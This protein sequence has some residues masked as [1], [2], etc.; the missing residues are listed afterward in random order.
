M[1]FS[2]SQNQ[3][4]ASQ[5]LSQMVALNI[6]AAAETRI[7]VLRAFARVRSS[8]LKDASSVRTPVFMAPGSFQNFR[9]DFPKDK[10]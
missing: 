7:V 5:T 1:R 4:D 8:T 6:I 9:F 10:Q 2:T 3:W